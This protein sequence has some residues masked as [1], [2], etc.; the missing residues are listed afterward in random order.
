MSYFQNIEVQYLLYLLVFL[1]ALLAF[2]AIAQLLMRGQ[3]EKTAHSHRLQL[4]AKGASTSDV[5]ALLSTPEKRGIIRNLPFIGDLPLLMRKAGLTIKPGT[6]LLFSFVSA[7]AV[8]AVLSPF[9]W[10]LYALLASLALCMVLPYLVIVFVKN[11]RMTELASQLPDTL[12]FMAR[13]LKVGHPLNVTIEAVSNQMADPIGSEFG[14]MHDQISYGDDLV[15]AFY[16][17]AERVD[18]EDV[19][20]LAV[21]VGIQHGTGGDLARVLS[22]LSNVI[23]DRITMRAMIKAISSE[24]RMSAY[25]LSSLPLIIFG[26]TSFTT[27]GYFGGVSQDPL[28]YPMITAII[29]LVITNFVVLQKLVR[30]KF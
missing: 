20:Y 17:F 28:Y 5:L 13:G 9:M 7:V 23:R 22:V 29:F 14:V 27:P 30:F 15:D 1:G 21:S 26:F 6:A 2:S 8:F 24:G 11:K 12:D 16:D 18:L 19:Q 4:I 10:V 3:D 25:F